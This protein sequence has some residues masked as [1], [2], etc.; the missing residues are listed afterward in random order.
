MSFILFWRHFFLL[1]SPFTD[2]STWN[3]ATFCYGNFSLFAFLLKYCQS[4]EVN[5]FQWRIDS[6]WNGRI[7]SLS[8]VGYCIWHFNSEH[9]FLAHGI[10]R[11]AKKF[12]KSFNVEAGRFELNQLVCLACHCQLFIHS[13]SLSPR[14]VVSSG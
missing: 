7:S 2:C 9:F 5:F 13:L 12:W 6:A 4:N 10:K 14:N 3:F 8:N 11:Y 1:A